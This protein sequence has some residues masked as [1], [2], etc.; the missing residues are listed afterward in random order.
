M[1]NAHVNKVVLGNETLIDLTADTV[2]AAKVIGGY[3]T[4]DKS[5]NIISGSLPWKGVVG[6]GLFLLDNTS[7]SGNK[8]KFT[9]KV[10]VSGNIIILS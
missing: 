7:Q 8:I 9:A 5:G 4:H 6:T 2:S 10:S 1:A 3:T